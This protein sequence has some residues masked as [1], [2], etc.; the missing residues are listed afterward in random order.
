MTSSLLGARIGWERSRCTSSNSPTKPSKAN[1]CGHS[2][3]ISGLFE[4]VLAHPKLEKVDLREKKGQNG[5][6][7][8]FLGVALGGDQH[9]GHDDDDPEN[10]KQEADDRPKDLVYA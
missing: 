1:G 6:P 4:K 8:L 7:Q 5:I 9:C 3:T 2:P 10:R